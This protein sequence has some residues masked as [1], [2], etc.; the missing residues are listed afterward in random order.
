MKYSLDMSDRTTCLQSYD[1]PPNADA[2]LHCMAPE[3]FEQN[4]IGYNY[5]ADIYSI[6]LLCCELSNGFVP[7]HD[8]NTDELLLC[9]ILGN[10]PL[11]LDSTIIPQNWASLKKTFLERRIELSEKLKRRHEKYS[12]R[13]YS[14]RFRDF[15]MRACLHIE[16]A[17]RFNASELLEHNFLRSYS[18][19]SELL[20]M[21]KKNY[22]TRLTG[23]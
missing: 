16:P 21:L 1:Y 17:K 18:D 3:I 11:L 20:R 13:K 2:I 15:V 4:T 19:R 8:A 7:F 10:Q 6:G 5:K 23:S 12:L 14:E 9:K 22:V